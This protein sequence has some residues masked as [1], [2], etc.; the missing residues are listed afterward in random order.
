MVYSTFGLVKAHAFCAKELDFAFNGITAA[1][2]SVEPADA[3]V[4]G[5]HPVSW[6]GQL[7]CAAA[8]RREWIVA[9]ALTHSAGAR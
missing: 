7:K 5:D 2:L 8:V 6:H 4:A 9:H 1:P 3:E